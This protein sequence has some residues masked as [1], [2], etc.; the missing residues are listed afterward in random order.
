MLDILNPFDLTDS[1]RAFL[2]PE[3]MLC[4]PHSYSILATRDIYR[5]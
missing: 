3:N 4:N 5:L 2:L 1:A